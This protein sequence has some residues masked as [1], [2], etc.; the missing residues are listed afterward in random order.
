[1]G[2]E[3][4]RDLPSFHWDMQLEFIESTS[5]ASSVPESI[6]HPCYRN[7]AIHPCM[8]TGGVL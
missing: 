2:T 1:M 3:G 8:S 5:I 6:H 4:E 7:N